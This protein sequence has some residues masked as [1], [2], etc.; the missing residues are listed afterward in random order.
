MMG[1]KAFVLVSEQG[2]DKARIDVIARRGKAPASFFRQIGAQQ[3][4][5]AAEDRFGKFQILPKRR[6]AERV[7]KSHK[8]TRD[9]GN[10]P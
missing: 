1:E 7:R 10:T 8:R 9:D 6:R 4:A 5:V 2:F 3:G